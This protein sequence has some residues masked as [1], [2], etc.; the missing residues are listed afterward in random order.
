MHYSK[1]MHNQ[2]QYT[3]YTCINMHVYKYTFYT[4]MWPLG[5][6]LIKRVSLLSEEAVCQ[7]CTVQYYI[8]CVLHFMIGFYFYMLC[9]PCTVN[10]KLRSL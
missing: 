4:Q 9:V 1:E 6:S 2:M 10:F 7:G 3:C 8:L 5:T